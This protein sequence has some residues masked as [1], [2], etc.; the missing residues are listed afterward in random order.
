MNQ[1][2]DKV[3]SLLIYRVI[4]PLTLI[5]TFFVLG[6]RTPRSRFMGTN[7]T[8]FIIRLFVVVFY[9]GSLWTIPTMYLDNRPAFRKLFWR[10]LDRGPILKLVYTINILAF[11]ILAGI[12]FRWAV[13]IFVPNYASISNYLAFIISVM[14]FLPVISKYSSF[15]KKIYA[16][17]T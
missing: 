8:D 6:E 3:I 2:L 16:D 11:S 15:R 4:L 13:G 17:N 10:S 5:F 12:I 7:I 14:Y 1:R 9:A